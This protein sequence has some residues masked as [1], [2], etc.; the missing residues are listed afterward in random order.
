MSKYF[1][2]FP[3]IQYDVFRTGYTNNTLFTNILM[4]LVVLNEVKHNIYA[5][6]SILVTDDY[7]TVEIL[8]EKY[9]GNP[10]YHWIIA[11]TNDMSDP[12]FDWPKNN[13][14]FENFINSKYGSTMNAMNTP[15]HYELITK[16]T[17]TQG[18]RV[19]IHT[20][21]IPELTYNNTPSYSVETFNLDSGETIVEEIST[22][23]VNCFDYEYKE[24]EEKRSLKIIKKEYLPQILE[25]FNNIVV[26]EGNDNIT[27]GLRSLNGYGR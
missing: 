21:G 23:M 2:K 26:R 9:Y 17:Y 14:E 6:Y 24:N 18:N 22:Q 27:R 10:E 1:D 3:T 11:Y 12:L 15:H 13:R 4:R 25:E 7:P 5:Y 19:D 16:R 20:I 8:A